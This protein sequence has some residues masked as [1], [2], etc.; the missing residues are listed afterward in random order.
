MIPRTNRGADTN[1]NPHVS[2]RV[3]GIEICKLCH[4]LLRLMIEDICERV[5][6]DLD[7]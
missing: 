7:E 6:E 4:A 3:T 2:N 1:W 5:G